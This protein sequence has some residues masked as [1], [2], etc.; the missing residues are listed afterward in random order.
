MTAPAPPIEGASW[1]RLTTALDTAGARYRV[2][3][4]R[5]LEG[6][7]PA[8]QDRRPS[9]GARWLPSDSPE[10]SGRVVLT[11]RSGCEVPEILAALGLAP[12]ELYDGRSELGRSPAG[13]PRR[14]ARA[15]SP[16]LASRRP[17][18][19]PHAKNSTRDLRA[20]KTRQAAPEP[21]EDQAH[22]HRFDW[23]APEAR[24]VYTDA[25]GAIV[26]R[27]DRVRCLDP[28]CP[29][30]AET[31]KA[32][33]T[34][35]TR[36]PDG[37]KG[38]PAALAGLLYRLPEI[39]AAVAA[40]ELVYLAEGEGDA[41]A[42]AAAGACGTSA[43]GGARSPWQPGHTDVLRG[44]RV[45]I[46]ADRDEQGRARARAVAA[47]LRGA[48]E[49][50]TIVQAAVDRPKAD[51]CDHLAAG[52]LLSAL[53]PLPDTTAAAVPAPR[54]AGS[55]GGTGVPR[56]TSGSG[57]PASPADPG[58]P[59]RY[60]LPAS[61]GAWAYSTGDDGDG[62][63]RGVYRQVTS[64]EREE[65]DDGKTRTV[66]RREWQWVEWLP[67]VYERIQHRDGAGRPARMSYRLGVQAETPGSGA[68]PDLRAVCGHLAVQMGDWA[69]PLGVP[70]SADPKV[71]QAVASA[72]WREGTR[73]APL[74]DAS[75]RWCPDGCLE[76]PPA[77]VGPAGYGATIGTER[78]ARAA[79]DEAAGILGRHPRA[80]LTA[81]MGTAAPYVAALRRQSFIGHLAGRARRGKTTAQNISA[82]VYG[83]PEVI[84]RPWDVSAIGLSTMAGEYGCL[85]PILN[86]LGARRGPR[87]DMQAIV[88]QLCEGSRRTK[89]TRDSRSMVTAPWRGVALSTG[90]V[91]L[92]AAL[93]EPGAVARVI[94]LSTPIIGSPELEGEEYGD[95]AG[96]ADAERLDA[97]ALEAYGWPLAW[98]RSAGITP[99]R[100]DEL[101]TAAAEDLG[102]PPGGSIRTIARHL[103]ASVA[104]AAA[105]DLA[106][107]TAC[108]RPAALAAAAE[109]LAE[110]ADRLAELAAP[111]GAKLADALAHAVTS[112]PDAFPALGALRQPDFRAYRPGEG[113]AVAPPPDGVASGRR[114]YAPPPGMAHGDVGVWDQDLARIAEAAGLQ[115]CM[116]AL[117]DL[118]SSGVLVSADRG[119]MTTRVRVGGRLPRAYVFRLPGGLA[120]DDPAAPPGGPGGDLAHAPA[121]AS[122]PDPN[123]AVTAV[124]DHLA[125][126]CTAETSP[127][128]VTG[129]AVTD[130]LGG[131]SSGRAVTVPRPAE[132]RG[133]AGPA[134]DRS[135]AGE[136]ARR[137]V[138]PAHGPVIGAVTGAVTAEA[139]VTA[140][141]DRYE[142]GAVLL[143]DADACY[144]GD[145]EVIAAG[146]LDSLADVI[147]LAAGLGL[148]VSR[149]HQ[150]G[151]DADPALYLTPAACE[152]YGLPPVPPDV[153]AMSLPADHPAAAG[154]REAGW[155]VDQ[156][157]T[158]VQVWRKAPER[159]SVSLT[160]LGWVPHVDPLGLGALLESGS[161]SPASLACRLGTLAERAWPVTMSSGVTA[162]RLMLALR[163]AARVTI[164]P[165]SGDRRRTP[166]R[167]SLH[168]PVPP[169]VYDA[170]DAHPAARGRPAELACRDESLTWCRQ[171]GDDERARPYAVAVDV[172][173]MFLSAAGVPVGLTAPR[174]MTAD[175]LAAVNAD[176]DGYLRNRAGVFVAEFPDLAA[177]VDP[178][179][180][181]PVTATGLWPGGPVAVHAPTLRYVR[182]LGARVV[183]TAGA[184]HDVCGPYLRPWQRRL[185]AAALAS[186]ADAGITPDMPAAEYL[187]GLPRLAERNPD[188]AAVYA[189]VKQLAKAGIG[190]LRQ[191]PGQPGATDRATW[192]PDI[193]AEVI[194]AAR[195]GI[196]RRAGKVLA[197]TG[198]APIAVNHDAVMYASA[199]PD[200]ASVVPWT[201]EGQ[202]V[203]GAWVIGC[204]PGWVKHSHTMP[205]GEAAAEIEAGD[206]PAIERHRE[207]AE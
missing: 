138:S 148:G 178:R 206:N 26:G 181:C 126:P 28:Q 204:R 19:G 164:D 203:P 179:M 175:E 196:N 84:V 59:P 119:H 44:A 4:E 159:A 162:E 46:I 88:F 51:V 56:R 86:E 78:A 89:A 92:L 52:L 54:A 114:L 186:L 69:E 96:A 6:K 81:G 147:E 49:S 144:L 14:S 198:A 11:C 22:E 111:P 94:E 130:Q 157:K 160:L 131:H 182:E 127:G 102:M 37:R 123:M 72:I 188:A 45:V 139:A 24:H 150:A 66:K 153:R 200:A 106:V 8:H 207:G 171:P 113:F 185:T 174:E 194:S 98:L 169:S 155:Q 128:A 29:D 9:F 145:G 156:I 42:I 146:G 205:M 152:R 77:D 109:Y 34:F 197:L 76:L 125:S 47:E 93:T 48:A 151:R 140:S 124:T 118:R 18:P 32:G 83:D 158:T 122:R 101:I 177:L 143:A 132:T 108:L 25:D 190:R 39:R 71:R 191:D 36:H 70:L 141:G 136:P 12:A 30:L 43:Y 129:G 3:G 74:V 105:L 97:L 166:V 121:H 55:G 40:G 135:D 154:L 31:G 167:G 195:A 180:P 107:G 187:S 2:T 75:P 53:V 10:R 58:D 64:E 183:V 165:A 15:A 192:R 23:R 104:G 57:Q 120:D 13:A 82:A 149:L 79:W 201:L 60:P 134:G 133:S 176:P 168:G 202:G 142:L 193:R 170:H 67:Y 87:S 61:S 50:V 103:A 137:S 62:R 116:T 65:D 85:P 100:F 17:R 20:G 173:M 112:R 1:E 184:V 63:E 73:S 27:V 115:D 7:C 80:A 110:M 99:A 5:A 163:P 95:P 189:A 38:K 91:S 16:S 161:P 117:R 90:N 41:D 33:K 21:G 68:N 199:S 172:N 35:A